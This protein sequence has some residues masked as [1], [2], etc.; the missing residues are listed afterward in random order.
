MKKRIIIIG[1]GFA[2]LTLARHLEYPGF[3]IILI[4]RLNHHQFQPL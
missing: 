4:D 3:E 2:G 1:A